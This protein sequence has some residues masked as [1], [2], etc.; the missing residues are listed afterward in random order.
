MNYFESQAILEQIV[1]SNNILINC[2][3]GPDQDSVGSATAMY[4]ILTN[5]NKNV[6]MI[7]PDKVPGDCQ[8]IPFSDKVQTID[9][10]WFD[11]SPYDLFF[12]LDS[13]DLQQVD[14]TP[15]L[16]LPPIKKIVIDH[17]ITNTRFGDINLVDGSISSVAELVYRIFKD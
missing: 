3:R 14:R 1:K 12:I 16:R 7:C 15:N 6:T 10:S 17:H 2:H 4:Q 8:F 9:Y 13:G 5:M 11:F